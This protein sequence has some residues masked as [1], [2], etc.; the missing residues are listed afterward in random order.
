KA[1]WKRYEK[2]FTIKSDKEILAVAYGPEK[3]SRAMSAAVTA[4]FHRIPHNW[5][6]EIKGKYNSQYSAGGPDGLIDGLRG[7]E[8]WR[9][10]NWQGYQAQDF[11]CIIDLKELKTIYAC[12][13]SF[14]Q[15]SRSWIL[16]PTR[17]EVLT[18]VDGKNYTEFGF[19]D[20]VSDPLHELVSANS[21]FHT[22]SLGV[23]A[24]YVKFKAKNFGKLPEGHAGYNM[25]GDAFIFVDEVFIT[26]NKIKIKK[27]K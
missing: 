25:S 17:V 6:V 24:K 8:N 11:E 21:Y 15:D 27:E 1:E 23:K 5:S 12:G 4:W 7:D 16:L 10:G 3:E 22:Q 26:V 14:L 9:K 18:S 2:P 13:A 20:I 19:T